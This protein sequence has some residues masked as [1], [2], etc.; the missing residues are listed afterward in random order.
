MSTILRRSRKLIVS[1][2]AQIKSTECHHR[3]AYIPNRCLNQTVTYT[4]YSN[5]TYC[6]PP[7]TDPLGSALVD[8][9]TY[10]AICSD[11]LEGL[12]EYFDDL[13]ES[14]PQLKSADVNYSVRVREIFL[15]LLVIIQ[16][17]CDFKIRTVC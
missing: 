3:I 6:T 7:R 10:E 11:T 9:V 12:C 2:L 17:I 8:L 1:T 4:A 5:R 16:L 13:V 14:T 15:C